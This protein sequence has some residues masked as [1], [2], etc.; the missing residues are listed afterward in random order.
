LSTD[1][2]IIII[3]DEGHTERIDCTQCRF[4]SDLASSCFLQLQGELLSLR[5]LSDARTLGLLTAAWRY[6]DGGIS[7]GPYIG[8]TPPP[9]K[10]QS[11]E[12][13]LCTNCSRW[14]QAAVVCY[15]LLPVLAYLHLSPSAHAPGAG[16]EGIWLI[17]IYTPKTECLA[18]PLFGMGHWHRTN[19]TYWEHVELQFSSVRLSSIS[20]RVTRTSLH[21]WYRK[22]GWVTGCHMYRPTKC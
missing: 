21:T 4:I 18:A 11:L 5:R 14:R 1:T 13:I 8:Y 17:W 10:N 16:C 9:K 15:A 19:W 2:S 7:V 12:I 3:S 20:V 6:S 22:T